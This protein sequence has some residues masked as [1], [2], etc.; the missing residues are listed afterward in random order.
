[1][2]RG[3]GLAVLCR[4]TW[5]ILLAGLLGL[6]LAAAILLAIPP[7]FIAQATLFIPPPSSARTDIRVSSPQ[8]AGQTSVPTELLVPEP[9]RPPDA[10]A[11]ASLTA[12]HAAVLTSE[13]VLRRVVERERLDQD[14]EFVRRHPVLTR[15]DELIRGP[16]VTWD[17]TT[18]AVQTLAQDITVGRADGPMILTVEARSTSSEKAVRLRDA[19]L[20]VYQ[21][22]I[23]TTA[24]P[25]APPP[26][27]TPQDT[28]L[29]DI[30][31]KI[32][33]VDALVTEIQASNPVVQV[34]GPPP[35][36]PPKDPPQARPRL[37]P[38]L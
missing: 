23:R 24:K 19:L 4:H 15:I 17:A 6:L 25:D 3:G 14:P 31:A 33:I 35:S 20:D 7:T 12:W 9:E 37:P 34:D 27:A 28:R 32:A 26:V 13:V 11:L 16:S 21:A 1:M 29:S 5:S 38:P 30:K 8:D 36:D 22:Q 10:S 2:T 18:E